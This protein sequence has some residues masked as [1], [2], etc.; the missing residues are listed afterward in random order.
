MVSQVEARTEQLDALGVYGGVS[1]SSDPRAS[2]VGAQLLASGGNAVDAAI[3]VAFA[4]AVHEPAMSH[5]GGQGNMVVHMV[6]SNQTRAIDFYACA[7]GSAKQDMYEWIPSPTQGGYRFHTRDDRNTVGPS[8]VAIPGNV[9]GWIRAHRLWGKLRLSEVVAP[10]VH[11]AETGSRA[12]KR[13]ANFI[14]EQ[15][16]KLARFEASAQTFLKA[17]GS[18]KVEGEVI[19][20]PFLAQTIE[21]IGR[22]GEE[23]FYRGP[24]A[25]KILA[26]VGAENGWLSK[27]DLAKYP[28]KLLIE[29]EPDWGTFRGHRIAGA[30]AASSALLF[31]LLAVLDGQE[32]DETVDDEVAQHHFIIEAMKLAFAERATHIGDTD[33]VNVPLEGLSSQ[34]Y[35]WDRRA[36]VD[37][38]KAQFPGP[39]NPWNYQHA[40]P[41][42][43]KLTGVLPEEPAPIQGTTHHSHV[44]QWGNFVSISQSLGD[45]FGSCV[46]VPETGVI[47]N[48]AMK[49]FDPRPDAGLAGIAPYKRPMAPWPSLVFDDK[50]PV[51]ALGSPSGTRIPN[52]IAQVLINVFVHGMTLHKAVVRP[53]LHWSGDELEVERDLAARIG[54]G[55]SAL[56]HEV[57]ERGA[58]SPWFGAVQAVRRDPQTGRCEGVADPRRSG[59]AVGVQFALHH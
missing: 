49:L 17:D 16:E 52:A 12:T 44:D 13:T 9:A 15:Q 41:D 32:L 18:P 3:G 46:V 19:H 24:V 29:R 28:D 27:D 50:G 14:R 40:V 5:L 8:S 30:T 7:P 54:A 45:A 58:K 56:G 34:E 47:L 25:R 21:A 1:A 22:E 10:A 37:A 33:F 23:Y 43:R 48:N 57:K 55:L 42:S 11:A 2:A 35:G 4:L 36:L 51:M 20:Q 31:N 38:E 39:G 26:G 53:R 6:E 59:A